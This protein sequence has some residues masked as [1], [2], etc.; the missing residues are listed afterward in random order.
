ME[1][2]TK[3]QLIL[4]CLLVSIVTAVATSV[5]TV[6]LNEGNT[7]SD[8]TIYQVI[9]KSIEKVADIPTVKNIV[10]TPAQKTPANTELS[11]ADIADKKSQSLVRIYEKI[12]ETKSFVALGIAVGAKNM[13]LS[14]TLPDTVL[15]EH[16]FLAVTAD[17]RE[18]PLR[19][20][21]MNLTNNFAL[22]SIQYVQGEKNKIPPLALKDINSVKLGSSVVAL[23]GKESG[24]VISTGIV[25]EMRGSDENQRNKDTVVTDMVLSSPISGW[26]LFDTQGNLIAFEKVI[27][28][29]ERVSMFTN[30]KVLMMEL[31]DNL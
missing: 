17:S 20:E 14:S 24:N 18:I 29:Y 9:E 22:F 19:I 3:Q 26:L 4:V 10:G 6:S 25:T 11:P 27:A 15:P 2:I 12:G 8:R 28:D 7:G 23:G 5:A 1:Q 21:R 16:M 13:I 31:G 30:A